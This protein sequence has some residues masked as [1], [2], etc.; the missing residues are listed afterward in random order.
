MLEKIPYIVYKVW[1]IDIHSQN[2]S[3]AASFSSTIGAD[4]HFFGGAPAEVGG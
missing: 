2:R 3:T 1:P 4:H